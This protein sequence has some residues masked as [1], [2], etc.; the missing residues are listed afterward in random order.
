MLRGSVAVGVAGVAS[1]ARSEAAAAE[2]PAPIAAL[3]PMTDG[4][5]PITVDEHRRRIA[6]AQE[7]DGRRGV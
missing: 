1:A 5:A 2:V 6:R 4:V 3:T 7:L